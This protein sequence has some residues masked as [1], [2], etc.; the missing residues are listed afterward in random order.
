[1]KSSIVAAVLALA[2]ATA[3]HAETATEQ[4]NKAMV[5]KFWREVFDAQDVSKAKDFI[6]PGYIQHNPNVAQGRKAFEDYFGKLWPHPLAPA[7]IKVTHFDAVLADGDLVQL[8][9]MRPRPEP[10]APSKTYRS[11]WFDLLRVKDG[12]IVE[13]WDGA[14]KPTR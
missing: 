6:V 12:K 13:H 4:A 9:A 8:M 11:Y 10:G 2:C 14:L 3:A 1:M 5:L 7:Q